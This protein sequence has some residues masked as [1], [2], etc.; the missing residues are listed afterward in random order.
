MHRP[1]NLCG[2]SFDS[3]K[4]ADFLLRSV[5]ELGHT[6][7]TPIQE[8][9]IPLVLQGRD[10]IA[11]AQT[12][13]GK[14]AAFVL[15]ILQRFAD[16]TLN[17][18]SES[19][20]ILVPT[21][22][23][24][25]QVGNAIQAY[26]QTM[27][28]PPRILKV[29]GGVDIDPQIEAAKMGVDVVVATPGRL[30]DLIE[31]QAVDLSDTNL[32]VLDEADRLLALGFADQIDAILK[33]LPTQRQNL[34]FS[35]TFPPAVVEISD[36]LLNNPEKVQ[37]ESESSPGENIHQRAIEVDR[38]ERTALLRHLLETEKWDRVLV[39]VATKRRAAN[40]TAK[41][42]KRGIRAAVL[43]GDLK[44][45]RRTRALENFKVGKTQVLMATDLAARGID[46]ANLPC[47]VN[48]DL[49]RSAADYVHRIGRTGRAG[50][51]GVAVSFISIE[52]L[53]HFQLIEKRHEIKI[54]RERIEDFIPTQWDPNSLPI[55][56]APVK[57]KRKSK[58]DKSREAAARKSRTREA[59]KRETESHEIPKPESVEDDSQV[60]ISR[61]D[62]EVVEKA[63]PAEPEK[64]PV[65]EAEPVV[66]SEKMKPEQTT[67][68]R[69]I[70]PVS[71]PWAQALKK[72]KSNE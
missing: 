61:T 25:D 17:G 12:G 4:L 32:L 64:P 48:Y 21:R 63:V 66:P 24:A 36:T 55:P 44:Q 70:K 14:T 53:Q 67:E 15:P 2:V 58:K 52:D 43:H 54:E 42:S 59:E 38:G 45:D 34:L 8:K 13:S 26:S 51:S 41:L 60:A 31:R 23:L 6:I 7:P 16:S 68:A 19:S 69:P 10:L 50:E 1:S 28:P 47:V 11:A 40:I 30:M 3:L 18:N 71:D 39:F 62:V 20:L 5:N 33:Q 9:A 22:E 46:I 27:S 37:L 57:G 29:F 56:A 65:H 72:I 35:A 49:P